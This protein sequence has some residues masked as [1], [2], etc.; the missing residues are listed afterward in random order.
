M[1]Q[2]QAHNKDVTGLAY[3]PRGGLLATTNG[4]SKFVHLWDPATGRLDRKL[5]AGAPAHG[6]AFAPDAPL[7][8]AATD[9]GVRLWDTARWEPVA[10]LSTPDVFGRPSAVYEVAVG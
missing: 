2:W 5:D 1:F 7:L 3:D 4:T 9:V 10:D 6:L 8:A